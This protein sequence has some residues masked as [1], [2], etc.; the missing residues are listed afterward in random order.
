M[1]LRNCLLLTL[2]FSLS[3]PL[4]LR[5]QE[6]LEINVGLSTPGLGEMSDYRFFY[7]GESYNYDKN[8]S[9]MDNETYN[10]TLYPCFSMEFAY[11]LAE[12]GFFKRLDFVGYA[13]LHIVDFNDVN[14]VKKL[15]SKELALKLDYL[16]GIRYNI[17]SHDFFKMYS[18]VLL[19]GDIRDKSRYWDINDIIGVSA[20]Y[21]F[22]GFNFK[23]GRRESRLGALLELGYGTEYVAMEVPL[24]PGI[25]TGL[26]YKF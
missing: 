20:Q 12:S 26:S 13:S 10:S 11:K 2:V 9:K 25:R 23:L 22:L 17:I 7:I 19:G 6:K 4:M 21:T 16:F 15:S 24:I 1:H 18:Q 8:L 3:W 5:A 14:M